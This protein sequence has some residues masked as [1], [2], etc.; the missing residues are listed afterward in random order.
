MLSKIEN[1]P[2]GIDTMQAIGKVSREDY[3]GFV[4]PLFDE[5]A[6]GGRRV[7]VLCELGPE[8]TGVTPRGMWEDVKLGLRA[9]RIIDGCAIMTEFGWIREF[10]RLAAFF[11]PAPV[12]VFNLD[13]KAQAVDWLTS[14]PE[15]PGI[16]HH[17]L[18]DSGVVV[19][20]VAEPLRAQDFDAL[21]VSVDS[22]LTSHD[23]VNG[24]VIH[25]RAIPG[26]ENLSGLVRHIRFVHDHHRKI[27]RVA[28]AVDGR[29]AELGPRVAEHFV[30]AELRTFAYDDLDQAI[31]WAKAGTRRK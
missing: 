18:T 20:E 7:R 14:L 23:A 26:W 8:F 30:Q 27:G 9:W 16:S 19:I 12:R 29:L 31:E 21:A 24:L 5:A 1:V 2:A 6:R 25:A 4:V 13:D 10:T 11:L 28:L 15:G 22:W 3:E 17:M